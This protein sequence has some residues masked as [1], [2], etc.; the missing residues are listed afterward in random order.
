MLG[1]VHALPEAA[2]AVRY[3]LVVL[4]KVLERS[5]L[6]RA[7]LVCAQVVEDFFVEDEVA[8]VNAVAVHDILLGEINHNAVVYA[9]RSEPG[10]GPNRSHCPN[11][12]LL[13]VELKKVIEVY[14]GYA[15]AIREEKIILGD[16]LLYLLY[17]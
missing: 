3:K 8:A 13:E 5:I 9:K 17:P 15:I 12:P 10:N 6:Q 7:V 16:V 11:L 14:V 2:M 4:C 1:D